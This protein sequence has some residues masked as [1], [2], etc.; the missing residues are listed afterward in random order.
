MTINEL[1][2]AIQVGQP[3][4]KAV[5]SLGGDPKEITQWL[6][7]TGQLESLKGILSNSYKAVLADANKAGVEKE[8]GKMQ[9]KLSA[10]KSMRQYLGY[11]EA[12]CTKEKS[13]PKIVAGAVQKYGL[14]DAATVCGMNAEDWSE[15]VCLYPNVT[16][17]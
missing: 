17:F 1:K 13:T 9:Q 2:T 15:F 14:Q 6:I 5:V 8:F 4:T 16:I 11:W 12:V 10:L 3:F 7:E